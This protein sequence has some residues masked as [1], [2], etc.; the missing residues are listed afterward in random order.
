MNAPRLFEDY[1]WDSIL[2]PS[3]YI[4]DGYVDGIEPKNIGHLLTYPEIHALIAYIV[5][6]SD[7]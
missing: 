1:L 3:N 2:Y 6:Y 4:V 7:Q 5:H